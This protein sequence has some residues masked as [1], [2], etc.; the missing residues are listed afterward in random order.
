MADEEEPLWAV[1]FQKVLL[2]FSVIAD[3]ITYIPWTLLS[4]SGSKKYRQ[5][6]INI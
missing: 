6:K 5:G 2:I 1:I 4:V 3:I